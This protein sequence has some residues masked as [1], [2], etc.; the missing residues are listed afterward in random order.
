METKNEVDLAFEILADEIKKSSDSIA[1]MGSEAMLAHKNEL[2][3]ALS[4]FGDDLDAFSERVSSLKSDWKTLQD[5]LKKFN[6]NRPRPSSP[7]K[8]KVE[9]KEGE[10]LLAVIFPDGST[11][12]EVMACVTFAK[13]IEKI[14][15]AEVASIGIKLD[16]GPLVARSKV[17]FGRYQEAAREVRGGWFVNT[18]SSTQAKVKILTTIA[19]KCQIKLKI[20]ALK[21]L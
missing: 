7:I 11:I 9:P 6:P 17:S 16:G 4:H 3:R 13:C 15:A 20:R 21:K 19:E 8:T 10:R 1:A 2:A 14:G 18:H 12:C 5:N